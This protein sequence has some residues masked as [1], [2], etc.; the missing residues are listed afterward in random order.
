MDAYYTYTYINDTN[1]NINEKLVSF[2]LREKSDILF[3]KSVLQNT[4]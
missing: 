1:E 2:D 4:F 3:F